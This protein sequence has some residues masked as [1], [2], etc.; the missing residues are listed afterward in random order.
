M[1]HTMLH[2]KECN[3]LVREFGEEYVLTHS[4]VEKLHR[5]YIIITTEDAKLLEWIDRL[6]KDRFRLN[7]NEKWDGDILD[8]VHYIDP[9]E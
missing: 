5:R 4:T 3:H 2:N 9:F 7:P 1:R 8:H 6:P